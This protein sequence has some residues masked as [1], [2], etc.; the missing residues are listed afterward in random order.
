[1][2]WVL[3]S[4]F[5]KSKI[6]QSLQTEPSLSW[7]LRSICPNDSLVDFFIEDVT[8]YSQ[9]K[10]SVPNDLWFLIEESMSDLSLARSSW[11][12]LFSIKELLGDGDGDGDGG[13][14]LSS[15]FHVSTFTFASFKSL[16]MKVGLAPR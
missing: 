16:M 2:D 11:T 4:I 5:S 6:F 14:V 10:T 7:P 1:M 3:N 13:M 9:M 8:N 15:P 12:E